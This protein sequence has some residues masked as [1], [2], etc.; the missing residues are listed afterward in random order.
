MIAG[1][2]ILLL[3]VLLPLLVFGG[4]VAIVCLIVYAI[5]KRRPG[6]FFRGAAVVALAVVA[7]IFFLLSVSF[8][9][10]V[11]STPVQSIPHTASPI[12][13]TDRGHANFPVIV[14]MFSD[15]AFQF[16][17]MRISW[18]QFLLVVVITLVALRVF[19]RR[20]RSSTGSDRQCSGWGLGRFI[21]IVLVGLFIARAWSA[22]NTWSARGWA[23][24]ERKQADHDRRGV[25]RARD[26]VAVTASPTPSDV[27]AGVEQLWEKLNQPKIDLH[28]GENGSTMKVVGGPSTIEMTAAAAAGS[29]PSASV[30]APTSR[31]AAESLARSAA[32]LGRV[33][34]QVST[35]AQQV[36][37]TSRMVARTLAAAEQSADKTTASPA[38]A[39][40]SSAAVT[41]Q[42][43]ATSVH[44]IAV[45]ETRPH[46][47]ESADLNEKIGGEVPANQPRPAWVD[48]PQKQVGNVL[49]LVT[50][51][52]PYT[53]SEECYQKTDQ[54]LKIA[55]DNYVKHYIWGLDDYP[56]LTTAQDGS[57]SV[58]ITNFRSATLDRM[59][60]DLVYIRREIAKDEYL[61]TVE[62]SV[63]PMKNL[64]SRLEFTP[65]ID[66]DLRTRW[67]EFE[68]QAR[69]TE[70]G[71]L[72]GTLLGV[73]G[74]V[75]GL[76]KI[77][78]ATK[79]YYSKW[80]F[81]GAPALTVI[82]LGI[83]AWLAFFVHV[84][85]IAR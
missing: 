63:G 74:L 71:L 38:P 64:Y 67:T 18:G 39:A 44:P 49:R 34:A 82:V 69:V 60:I 85:T 52:G 65:D 80:L 50:V 7:S 62:R 68:R 20:E 40:K 61:E 53:T 81:L 57:P 16:D 48:E 28:A 59:G 45:A 70:V 19:S 46:D 25:E 9:T 37:D 3:L 84:A 56:S 21:L 11:A 14:P 13:T 55:T 72:S 58:K 12:V 75:F 29:S 43:P 83:G 24:Q 32:E 8:R 66:R 76:L 6:A 23:E 15:V 47:S 5:L 79:G 1:I 78:T 2:G 27:Q 77:D 41:T 17:G 42:K 33:I 36:S 4:M 22:S 30:E 73:I 51:A 54:L 31:T 10:S 35:I 26:H